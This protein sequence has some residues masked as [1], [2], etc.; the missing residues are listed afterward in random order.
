MP[1]PQTPNPTFPDRAA[2]GGILSDLERAL[3]SERD[4]RRKAE[5]EA[6]KARAEARERVADVEKQAGQVIPSPD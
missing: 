1:K 2:S 5:G 3:E 4:A 6:D